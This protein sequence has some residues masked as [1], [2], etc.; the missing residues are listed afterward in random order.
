MRHNHDYPSEPDNRDRIQGD[1]RAK[2]PLILAIGL[3]A[4][5]ALGLLLS[6]DRW[7]SQ[8]SGASMLI[9]GTALAGMFAGVVFVII[10][11]PCNL[12]DNW[13]HRHDKQW[14]REPVVLPFFG[15]LF[16]FL[17][18]WLLWIGFGVIFGNA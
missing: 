6:D 14:R 12:M 17:V 8:D 16:L 15:G 13:S 5:I 11:A 4:C 2:V 9:H 7:G 18:G 3:Y 10:W 1:A